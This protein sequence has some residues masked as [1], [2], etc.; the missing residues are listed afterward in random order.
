MITIRSTLCLVLIALLAPIADARQAAKA[1]LRVVP[2]M[3]L[4][5]YMGTWYE[6]A[7][8]PFG[9][10]DQC[11][12]DVTA[13][14]TLRDDGRIEILNRCRTRDGSFS[15]AKGIARRASARQPNTKLKVRFAPSW[16]SALPFVWGDYWITVLAPDYSYA[17]V[18]EPGRKYLWILSRTPSMDESTLRRILDALEQNGYDLTRLM[19]TQASPKG[20]GG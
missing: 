5:R 11:A 18:G 14:Y 10:Q 12:G 3:D 8:L 16:L 1:P 13:S 7:R 20:A 2:E 4:P 6:V 15:E 19:R 17:A 9:F